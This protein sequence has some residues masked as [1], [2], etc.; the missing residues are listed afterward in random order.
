MR[1]EEWQLKPDKSKMG[2]WQVYPGR[3]NR[4]FILGSWSHIIKSTKTAQKV[5]PT[6]LLL[7]PRRVRKRVPN[8][9]QAQIAIASN[10]PQS[11]QRTIPIAAMRNNTAW[12]A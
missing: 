6:T 8:I 5:S 10:L 3:T 12:I 9:F 4:N 2:V 11:L 7:G 1:S